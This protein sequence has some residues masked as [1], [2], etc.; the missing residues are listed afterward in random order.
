MPTR[1]TK[2]DLHFL[3]YLYNYLGVREPSI[4]KKY[5]F[6]AEQYTSQGIQNKITNGRKAGKIL[7]AEIG[8]AN[9]EVDE[10]QMKAIIKQREEIRKEWAE[11][12][13]KDPSLYYFADNPQL[14]ESLKKRG[15]KGKKATTIGDNMSMADRRR[16]NIGESLLMAESR[17]AIINRNKIDEQKR[18]KLEKLLENAKKSSKRSSQPESDDETDIDDEEDEGEVDEEE[19]GDKDYED[20]AKYI[21]VKVPNIH[22]FVDNSKRKRVDDFQEQMPPKKSCQQPLGKKDATPHSKQYHHISTL[23]S[24]YFF[25]A[26]NPNCDY[27]F[28]RGRVTEGNNETIK[29]SCTLKSCLSINL[30]EERLSLPL[31]N[32]VNVS[33][34]EPTNVL[35]LIPMDA[36]FSRVTKIDGTTDFPYIG[37]EI[38][39]KSDSDFEDLAF[40]QII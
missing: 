19:D 8:P 3:A 28:M 29:I 30:L 4:I 5:F 1:W 33:E 6:S 11:S 32:L 39:R 13:V 40:S 16:Q 27:T 17:A 10:K 2:L 23:T 20:D 9:G 37:F 34:P 31:D 26:Y 25:V 12:L 35:I 22:N 36:D 7:A 24:H 21:G 38:K 18:K 14:K 15:L